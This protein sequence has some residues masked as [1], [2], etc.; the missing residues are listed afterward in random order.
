MLDI[1][2]IRAEPDR[3]KAELA[4]VG[5]PASEI[6][7]LLDA[8]RRRR[9]ARKCCATRATWACLR[10][11]TD[12]SGV[13]SAVPRRLRTSTKTSTDPSSATRSISPARQR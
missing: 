8:D 5:F 10:P 6:D 13:P 9:E 11:S 2:L 7:A 1:R 12:S 4:K 3:V